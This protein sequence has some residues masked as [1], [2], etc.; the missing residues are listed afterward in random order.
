MSP[1]IQC[2]RLEV[3]LESGESMP[4]WHFED[5]LMPRAQVLQHCA[6]PNLPV[7][8]DWRDHRLRRSQGASFRR[9]EKV[10]NSHRHNT[11]IAS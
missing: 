8:L 9:R 6:V 10:R 5:R 3:L 11:S 1:A 7:N 4:E 2:T